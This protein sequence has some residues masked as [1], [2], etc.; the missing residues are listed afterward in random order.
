MSKYYKTVIITILSSYFVSQGF[1][2]LTCQKNGLAIDCLGVILVIQKTGCFK[3]LKVPA[4]A[5]IVNAISTANI[6]T[7]GVL[8]S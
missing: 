3:I 5:A 7:I 2:T 1:L 8:P 6:I 4:I